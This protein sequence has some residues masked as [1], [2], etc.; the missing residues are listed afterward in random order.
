[1]VLG[2]ASARG[3]RVGEAVSGLRTFVFWKDRFGETPKPTLETSV[4][5]TILRLQFPY[6]GD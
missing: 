6:F 1:M 5:P 4:L 2:S 3:P